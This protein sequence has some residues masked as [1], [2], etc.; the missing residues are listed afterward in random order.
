MHVSDDQENAQ[1]H[2]YKPISYL[3]RYFHYALILFLTNSL[4]NS[5]RER[6]QCSEAGRHYS[7]V[8]NAIALAM[9]VLNVA[10]LCYI[11]YKEGEVGSEAAVCV[12]VSS[13]MVGVIV[14]LT[15]RIAHAGYHECIQLHYVEKQTL[16]SS[17]RV[18]FL[19]LLLVFACNVD[20]VM[21]YNNSPGNV[22]WGYMFLTTNWGMVPGLSALFRAVGSLELLVCAVSFLMNLLPMCVGISGGYRRA[23]RW[24]WLGCLVGMLVVE[25][26][27]F[28][29]YLG[30]DFGDRP[31]S[32]GANR[33]MQI[34]LSCNLVD[35]LFWEW[36][37]LVV[38][39]SRPLEEAQAKE[40]AED[41]DGALGEQKDT[42]AGNY[43]LHP[44]RMLKRSM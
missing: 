33:M 15:W 28:C 1:R 44:T 5:V 22:I 12:A 13:L 6:S 38:T 10:G 42:A 7:V 19:E 4:A 25:V 23:L 35:M 43:K 39:Y 29:V 31:E 8:Y 34:F 32:A 20:W 26:A 36:G 16:F 14:V 18:I 17:F 37:Y 41:G 40:L 9:L 30:Y 24:W 2:K 3:M 27:C 11:N 21:R